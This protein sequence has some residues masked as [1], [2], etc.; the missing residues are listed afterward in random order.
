[1]FPRGVKQSLVANNLIGFV[2]RGVDEALN[3]TFGPWLLY[4]PTAVGT[5]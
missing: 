1:M 4:A 3:L 5:C 2:S